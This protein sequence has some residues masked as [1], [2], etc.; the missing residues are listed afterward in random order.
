MK[1]TIII[2]AVAV[3]STACQSVH[4]FT[5]VVK[6]KPVDDSA[7]ITL[8]HKGLVYEDN[9][10]KITYHFFNENGYV[11]FDFL[12]KTDQMIEID[13]TR[14]FFTRNGY[15]HNYLRSVSEVNTKDFNANIQRIVIAPHFSKTI[16]TGHCIMNALYR[17]CALNPFPTT[18]SK[19]FFN[20]DKSPITFGNLLTFKIGDSTQDVQ[21]SNDFY[22]ETICNFS[23]GLL[24]QVSEYYGDK[25][26]QGVRTSNCNSKVYIREVSTD[27]A[28]TFYISYSVKDG[29][30]R[31]ITTTKYR[32]DN[33]TN[34]YLPII[35]I[36]MMKK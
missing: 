20:H 31:Y 10:C 11:S 4:H 24:Y 22:I 36:P 26:D 27:Q 30:C 6:T 2:L 1:K 19:E 7:G 16:E 12:N 13:L 28:G 33:R 29:K 25:C 32:W 21:I 18:F 8:T 17:D 3:I 9:H 5:Q 35:E 23:D 34:K 15:C 14:T